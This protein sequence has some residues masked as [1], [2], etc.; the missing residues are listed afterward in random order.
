MSS[1]SSPLWKKVTFVPSLVGLQ[2]FLKHG[3][4]ICSCRLISRLP[5]AGNVNHPLGQS[6]EA[7][8][9]LLKGRGNAPHYISTTAPLSRQLS[10]FQPQPLGDSFGNLAQRSSITF[11]NMGVVCFYCLGGSTENETKNF[12]FDISLKLHER[13]S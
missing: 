1:L 4:L 11:W 13:G 6:L 7:A 12:C 9:T 3:V 8:V 5:L 10:S 2:V